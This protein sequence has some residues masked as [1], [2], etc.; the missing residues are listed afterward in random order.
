MTASQP[1]G[2]G[3]YFLRAGVA[4]S[5]SASNRKSEPEDAEAVAPAAFG[6]Q[7]YLDAQCAVYEVALAELAAGRKRGHW[8]WFILPQLRGLGSSQLSHEYGV[9]SL[10][11][12]QAYLANPVLVERLHQ[13]VKAILE[14][15][16]KPIEHILGEVDALKYR[17][18]LTLFHLAGGPPAQFKASLDAFYA[19]VE[20]T[21]TRK[22]LDTMR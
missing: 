12:A 18:C 11:E 1:K 20:C 14:Y 5:S 19:G 3:S 10:C 13:C 15:R 9:A 22:L 6:L 8:M 7:R 21:S 16:D 2:S 17:S 4:A